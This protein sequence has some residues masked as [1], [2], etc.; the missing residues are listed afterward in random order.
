MGGKGDINCARFNVMLQD[1]VTIPDLTGVRREEPSS[2]EE[3][4]ENDFSDFV[5]GKF[6]SFIRPTGSSLFL[7]VQL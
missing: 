2:P 3:T 6:L 5:L 4:A 7:E 1:H